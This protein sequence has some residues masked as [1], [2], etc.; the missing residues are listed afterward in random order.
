M[1]GL[2]AEDFDLVEDGK[3]ARIVS[4]QYIDTTEAEE[5]EAI[6]L[7]P[8]ARRHFL[9]LFDMSFTDPG[10]LHRAREAA[11]DLVRRRLASPA[12]SAAIAV[13]EGRLQD[14]DHASRYGD[15]TLRG[16]LYTMV[17]Q[18]SNAD[19]VVHSIDVTGLGSD[20]GLTRSGMNENPAP[21]TSG[22]DSLN[23]LA[24]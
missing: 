24:T 2:A 1:R 5:A 12:R 13:T 14:V 8:A 3:T 19:C 4:F 15:A 18:L 22:R 16:T 21:E 11:S 10:G 23:F 9:L 7:S 17:R 6:Q 20:R